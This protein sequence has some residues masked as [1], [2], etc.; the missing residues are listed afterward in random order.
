MSQCLSKVRGFT[1]EVFFCFI[2]FLISPK[3]SLEKKNLIKSGQVGIKEKLF[4]IILPVG[5]NQQFNYSQKSFF[6][7]KKRFKDLGIA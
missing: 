1:C 5:E 6:V 7:S 3:F 4:W 2:F